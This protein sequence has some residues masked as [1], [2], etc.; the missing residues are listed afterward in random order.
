MYD[1]NL[2]HFIFNSKQRSTTSSMYLM[3]NFI[4]FCHEYFIIK[5][6]VLSSKILPIPTLFCLRMQDY[7]INM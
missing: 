4:T 6:L 1:F 7:L 2:F 5:S 3:S